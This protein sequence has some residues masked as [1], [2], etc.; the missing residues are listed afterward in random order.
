MEKIF[1]GKFANSR[2]V[3]GLVVTLGLGLGVSSIAT[4]QEPYIGDI[5]MVGFNFAQRG[6][7]RCDGQL[8][9][10]ASNSALFSLFGTI[11]GGDGRTTFAL[12]DCRGRALIHQGRGAGLSDRR[13][14]QRMGQEAVTL[15]TTQMP[16]HT[17]VATT[18]ST[19]MATSN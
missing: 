13:I 2:M 3:L 17:H 9:S 10:V 16:S 1:N 11:Y 6:W 14:G 5:K 18:D 7:A 12:P 19:L 4:A 15:S 8:L